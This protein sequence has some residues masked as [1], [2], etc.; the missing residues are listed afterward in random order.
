MVRACR[1]QELPKAH[2]AMAP[3]R[4]SKERA[5]WGAAVFIGVGV[6]VLA[7]LLAFELFVIGATDHSAVEVSQS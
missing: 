1:K 6:L 4:P 7:A 3:T 5:Q 2:T